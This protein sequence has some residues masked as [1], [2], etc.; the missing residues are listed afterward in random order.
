MLLFERNFERKMEEDYT[1]SD[2][3]KYNKITLFKNL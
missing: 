1:N 3:V 2:T